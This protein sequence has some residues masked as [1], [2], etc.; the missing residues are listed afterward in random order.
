MASQGTPKHLVALDD[1]SIA[2]EKN[3]TMSVGQEEPEADIEDK[4]S[5]QC[6]QTEVQ[7]FSFELPYYLR[8]LEFILNMFEI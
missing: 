6:L 1:I 4:V 5:I 2:L 3:S 8:N 7:T